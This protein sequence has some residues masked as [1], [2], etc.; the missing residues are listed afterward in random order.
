MT[1]SMWIMKKLNNNPMK[2]E[3]I[4]K[5]SPHLIAVLS[6]IALC[7]FYFNPV[8]EGK[9]LEQGDISN[10]R[11]MSKEVQD[12]RELNNDKEPLW[13]TSMFGGMPA[14]QVSMRSDGNLMKKIDKSI[15][16]ILPHPAGTVLLLLLGFYI[17]LL[18][19]KVNPWLGIIGAI[20][21]AFSSYFLIVIEAGHNSKVIAIAY[22]PMVIAG[23]ILT[24]RKK[25]FLGGALTTL[26]ASLELAANHYQVTYYLLIALVI[27]TGFKLYESVKEKEVR[28]KFLKPVGI[29]LVA[30]IIAVLPNITRLWI[31]Y[32]YSEAST[33]GKT[34]L[35]L[36]DD[37]GKSSGLDK[38]YV[39]NWSYGVDE[40][41]TLMIPNFKGGASGVIQQNHKDVL[42]KVDRRFRQNIARSN[43]YWGSQPFTSGPVYLGAI[44]C[45]LFVLGLFLIKGTLKWWLLVISILAIML[46][47]GKNFMAF[48]ELFLN[49]FPLYN[50]FRTVT[51][52]LILAQLA[53][54]LLGML[55]LSKV[56]KN[57][58]LLK[59]Q[60]KKLYW[61]LGLTGGLSLVMYFF[62]GLFNSFISD[63][64]MSSFQN[65]MSQQPK[66]QG[67][68]REFIQNLKEARISIFKA[69]ALR[70][71]FFIALGGA[72]LF[73]YS[74]QKLK[75]ELVYV[76]IGGLILVDLW[77]VDKR[78]INNE[79][80][81]SQKE[82]S[83][84]FP[85]TQADFQ[86]LNKELSQNPKAQKAFEEYK[87]HIGKKQKE[88]LKQSQ[89]RDLKFTALRFNSN[90]R[91]MNT[92]VS[93]FND[94]STS[95]YHKSI[96]GYH[97]AK[98][99]RY[100]DLISHQI[101]R[102]NMKVLNMLNTKYF[103]VAD[104]QG[105]ARVQENPEALGSA[106]FVNDIKWV[107]NANEEMKALNNFTPSTT[108][109][110]DKRFKDEVSNEN[111]T[112]G[113]FSRIAL[114][115]YQSNHLTYVSKAKEKQFA[116][117]SEIYY[118]DEKGWK[119]YID[120]KRV[121]HVR[122]N[123]VLRGLEI[124]PGEHTVEFKFEPAAYYTGEKIALGSSIF[125][126]LLIFGALYFEYRKKGE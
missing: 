76:L 70:T 7:L 121:P 16:S 100:Q 14:Y 80:F 67:Q 114:K 79:N 93:T 54:P 109:V 60:P 52:I 92:A 4:Q 115:E 40:T 119:A 61:A 9:K 85:P 108:A 12:F 24:F 97:G 77:S 89:L 10:W 29:L 125:T 103:I 47:W 66:M 55:A 8:L 39:T 69:D 57:P 11:G 122:V 106:W 31:T 59:E 72:V 120:G 22:V 96:G 56:I 126:I 25:Y 117:F 78:Y 91:V 74:R 73:L 111:F 49:Y 38:D 124:P 46:S 63:A 48:T 15:R 44:V 18:S 102:N 23:V 98:M 87:A 41:F 58:T 43:Q 65:Q 21:F 88:P 51:I 68:I 2:K 112:S 86:I 118:N 42:D 50:K 26:F 37:E 95:Y 113:D 123:Y 45:F 107:E 104:Q 53:F 62:P 6:F 71:I 28:D 83:V 35:S 20:A 110:I 84:P 64:E 32:E 94:A 1:E 19:L 82:Y 101:S 33:R 17:L 3:L 34:E 116:V 36:N 30:G 5:F 27:F 90:Y 99:G 75:K 81:V 105:G 13:T